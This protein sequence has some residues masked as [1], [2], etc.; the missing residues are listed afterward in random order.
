M[1]KVKS[2]QKTRVTFTKPGTEGER[3]RTTVPK[4]LGLKQGDRLFWVIFDDGTAYVSKVE[5]EGA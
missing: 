3:R 4:D 1:P 2:T 5:K